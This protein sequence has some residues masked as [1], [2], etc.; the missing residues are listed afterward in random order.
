MYLQLLRHGREY[1]SYTKFTLKNS[2][3][4]TTLDR[5][6]PHNSLYGFNTAG[7]PKKG[8]H[9]AAYAQRHTQRH[10]DRQTDRHTHVYTSTHRLNHAPRCADTHTHKHRYAHTF[11]K[12]YIQMHRD[13]E[14]HTQTQTHGYTYSHTKSPTLTCHSL[15]CRPTTHTCNAQA[16]H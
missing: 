11:K 4:N 14:T 1:F 3:S 16:H 6:T 8:T 13:S 9:L 7:F 12:T 10:T 15:E 2:Y 5:V